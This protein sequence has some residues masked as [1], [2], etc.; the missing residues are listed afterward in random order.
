MP[1]RRSFR[2]LRRDDLRGPELEPE[3]VL[4]PQQRLE[5]VPEQALPERAQRA[6]AQQALEPVAATPA[7][8][9]RARRDQP[10]LPQAQPL[11]PG[12]D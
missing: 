1:R 12:A 6:R 9:A 3:L 11:A 10:V 5:P 8:R 2:R 4:V 7:Q